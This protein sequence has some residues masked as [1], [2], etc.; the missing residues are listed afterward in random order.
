MRPAPNWQILIMVAPLNS[1]ADEGET[2]RRE[3]GMRG[4]PGL[5]DAIG[6]AVVTRRRTGKGGGVLLAAILAMVITSVVWIIWF[7]VV[8]VQ[9]IEAMPPV[10]GL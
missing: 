10:P 5:E 1:V 2:A 3:V 6:R 8:I 9:V 7:V 4:G